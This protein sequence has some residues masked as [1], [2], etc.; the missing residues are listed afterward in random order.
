[1]ALANAR[2]GHKVRQFLGT[3]TLLPYWLLLPSILYLLLFFVVPLSQAFFVAFQDADGGWTLEHFRKMMQDFRFDDAVKYTFLLA[4]TIVPLQ[5]ITALLIA[6]LV[7]MRF[8][9]SQ[10]FLYICAIPLGLSDLAAGLV[11]LSIF[12][13]RGYLNSL[14]HSL[15]LLERPVT[16]LSYE[17]VDWLFG[18][19]VVAE[20]WRATAIV[21]V[22]LIAG[23]QMISKDY[24]ESA[25]VLGANRLQKLWY[26]ILPL[27][28]PSLQAALIIRTIF[29]FE[30]FAVVIALAGD[31]L[32]VLAGEAFNWYFLYQNLPIASAYA[33]LIMV[34]SVLITVFYLRFFRLREEERR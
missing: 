12:A 16:I 32:P 13:D 27:L 23:L 24:L 11:W 2:P 7:N 29:A 22:V 3:D 9:G 21:L 15:G 10:M 5:L 4:V 34:I 30:I 28:R 26:V 20:H 33:V 6:L 1:M 25:D 8:R 18:A 17:H 19:V 31:F 14:L